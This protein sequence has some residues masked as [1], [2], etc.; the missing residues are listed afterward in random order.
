MRI[1]W[2]KEHPDQA[3]MIMTRKEF[4]KNF[5]SMYSASI[6]GR[7]SSSLKYCQAF[8]YQN[9]ISGILIIPKK[10]HP[11]REHIQ[12][13]FALK[14]NRLIIICSKT[15]EAKILLSE[16]CE[17]YDISY[18]HPLLFLLEFLLFLTS[19]D[20]Y[21]LEDYNDK[22]EAIEQL[23][24]RG[25]ETD[26][27][28]FTLATRED[29]N[30]LSSYYLQ[31][32]AVGETMEEV[33]VASDLE[34][35]SALTSLYSARISQLSSIVS[36]VK[37]HTSQIWDLRQTQ[38]SD[39][40]NQ[41]S[42]TLTIITVIF[43][44]LTMITGW[45]GMNFYNMPSIHNRYGYL[46]TIIVVICIVIA[47]LLYFLF[48]PAIRS[49]YGRHTVTQKQEKET[50]VQ[51]NKGDGQ[52]DLTRRGCTQAKKKK[53]PLKL[54]PGEE[55]EEDAGSEKADPS[56]ADE[57][58]K[59]MD[60][61]Q[62]ELYSLQHPDLNFC[63]VCSLTSCEPLTS[64]VPESIQK[65]TRQREAQKAA[66]KALAKKSQ[67]PAALKESETDSEPASAG[68]KSSVTD[69]VLEKQTEPSSDPAESAEQEHEESE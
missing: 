46:T 56:A 11:I 61:K 37:A 19:E 34:L 30:V 36:D 21:F 13:G 25:R 57:A 58:E 2:N 38:L 4:K 39:R 16:F 24:F 53:K 62:E 40:Q 48:S 12:F 14:D 52:F 32:S 51:L 50:L 68:L 15:S 69:P 54:A 1:E 45:F 42:T 20:V 5:P 47:E 27:E 59:M 63:T 66:R 43:L 55:D 44:P 23:L 41:I 67:D 60:S 22:L 49:V 17:Q 35:P 33:A 7:V 64:G 8:M 28:E 65:A 9:V 29:M 26:M 3:L 18:S 10:E 31:L 6:M